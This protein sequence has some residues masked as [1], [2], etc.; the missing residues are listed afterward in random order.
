MEFV[1]NAADENIRNKY[2]IFADAEAEAFE[3]VETAAHDCMAVFPK[4][5]NETVELSSGTEFQGTFN[6]FGTG[7]ELE[8]KV[9]NFWNWNGTVGT[10]KITV[11]E[12]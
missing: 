1:D 10:L 9:L 5:R 6:I 8:L 7:T 2:N 3:D 11:L 4:F 12:L